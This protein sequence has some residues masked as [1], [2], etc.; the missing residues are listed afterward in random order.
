MC[1][2]SEKE[3]GRG[4][5]LPYLSANGYLLQSVKNHQHVL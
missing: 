4:F 5:F 1:D 3:Y 2:R